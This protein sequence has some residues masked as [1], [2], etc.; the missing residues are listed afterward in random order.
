MTVSSGRLVEVKFRPWRL[1]DFNKTSQPPPRDK[2]IF[3]KQDFV[4]IYQYIQGWLIGHDVG[5]LVGMLVGV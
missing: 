1:I 3:I 2:E 4:R 5:V